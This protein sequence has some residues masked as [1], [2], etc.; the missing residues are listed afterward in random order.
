M[1]KD[2]EKNLTRSSVVGSR[3]HSIPCK[4]PLENPWLDPLHVGNRD[5]AE[6]EESRCVLTENQTTAYIEQR[7]SV[8]IHYRSRP[9]CSL[10][11]NHTYAFSSSR[12]MRSTNQ[13]ICK[14]HYLCSTHYSVAVEN[15]R[16]VSV[17]II[18]RREDSLL[19][20]TTCRM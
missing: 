10:E 18:R 8:S 3:R 20:R 1:S 5:T 4:H 9:D 13:G 16:R 2:E 7:V 14:Y 17:M 19:A 11:T 12:K 15:P 6:L